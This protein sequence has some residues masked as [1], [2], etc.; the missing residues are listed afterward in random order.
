MNLEESINLEFDIKT[1][2]RFLMSMNSIKNLSKEICITTD[3]SF[4]NSED[5]N[6]NQY[7]MLKNLDLKKIRDCLI[8]RN[9]NIDKENFLIEKRNKE[10]TFEI[11]ICD[12]EKMELKNELESVE[13]E[14]LKSKASENPQY[15]NTIESTSNSHSYPGYIQTMNSTSSKESK[16]DK[17]K[18]AKELKSMYTKLEK[19]L[20]EGKKIYDEKLKK[21]EQML[22]EIEVKL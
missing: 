14:I 5:Y 9:C 13:A 18:K 21:N 22:I 7:V 3:F 8:T 16:K 10:K 1:H 12:K 4:F 17:E 2:K 6:Y 19:N 15:I 11:K 20:K